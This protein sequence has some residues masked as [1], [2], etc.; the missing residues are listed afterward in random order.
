MASKKPIVRQIAWISLMPQ[1][2]FMGV[3][4]LLYSFIIE[5]FV[6]AVTVA[7]I[8]YLVISFT[9]RFSISHN[10]RKGISL[11]KSNNYKGAIEQFEKSY[12][13]F[14]KHEWIDKFRY[15]TMLSSSRVSYIEMSLINIAFANTQ[16]GN[17]EIAK[18]YYKRCLIEFPD[19]EMAKTALN[20]IS[21]IEN[22]SKNTTN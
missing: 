17:G 5:P 21:S 4:V 3:L 19:S 6:N 16:I 10:H 2:L 14:K 13:F 22:T 8:T 7:M 9:L 20:M 12:V 15:V 1:L 18:N 11:I